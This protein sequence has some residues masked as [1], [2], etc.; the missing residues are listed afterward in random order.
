[1]AR[2]GRL[3]SGA[4][5]S[6][7]LGLIVPVALGDLVVLYPEADNTLYEDA[8]G[9]R[10]NG[11]GT[12]MF[13]GRNS[14]QEDSIR[15]GLLSFDIAA[16]LPSG[17][18][19][20]G[21]TLSLENSAANADQAFVGLHR[22]VSAW[23]EG[24]SIAGGSGG[25]GGPAAANDATWL[26]T[27]YPGDF[28]SRP[29]GDFVEASSTLLPVHG[30]GRDVWDSTPALVADVQM[31]LDAPET[32]FGWLVRGDE[33]S[34]GTA[35]RFATREAADPALRPAL[36]IT[37]TPIPEPGA[38]LL[39]VFAGLVGGRRYTGRGV[40]RED[41]VPCHEASDPRSDCHN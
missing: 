20:D 24:M 26:H 13:A 36:T 1:M 9:G 7:T 4:V 40:P 14:Q 18:T 2:I 23:G 30:P 33:L 6:W 28:W 17:A 39:L 15:R 5:L 11:T 32:N 21:V 37:Y 31:F 12:S 27:F 3:L 10:S 35:K 34:A 8:L 16:G 38:L 19:I 22:V 25:Q 41:P 29:G